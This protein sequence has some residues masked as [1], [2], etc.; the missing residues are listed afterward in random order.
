MNQQPIPGY[1]R[2]GQR[3]VQVNIEELFAKDWLAEIYSP[4]SWR[5]SL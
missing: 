4:E 2:K 1:F 5:R 3:P